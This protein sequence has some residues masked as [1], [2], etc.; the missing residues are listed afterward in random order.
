MATTRIVRAHKLIIGFDETT[1]QSIVYTPGELE[2][3]L[4]T[5]EVIRSGPIANDATGTPNDG[6]EWY[7][8]LMPGFVE[9]HTHGPGAPTDDVFFNWLYPEEVLQELCHHGTTSV[10]ATVTFANK[11]KDVVT[12]I[13]QR[14]EAI[15]GVPATTLHDRA[16]LEGVHCEG[17]MIQSYG[18]L[19]DGS[20]YE[21]DPNT[22]LSLYPKSL[23]IITIA[24]SADART[25]YSY[26][27]AAL[28]KG[29]VVAIGHDRDT[30]AEDII[31]QMRCARDCGAQPL[32]VTHMFNVMSH[33]HRKPGIV[34]F[35]LCNRYPNLPQ[36]EGLVPPTVEII[37]DMLHVDPL[38]L[39]NTL[40]TLGDRGCLITDAIATKHFDGHLMFNDRAVEVRD[41]KLVLKGT[42]TIAGSC[43]TMDELLRNAVNIIGLPITEAVRLLSERPARVARLYPYIGCLKDK[44]RADFVALSNDLE[45]RRVVVAG[46]TVF[47]SEGAKK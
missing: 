11:H 41:G 21:A 28:A 38:V 34:D 5:G 6:A 32:H 20:D 15:Y 37:G 35:A 39:G 45:V 16:S 42:S 23:K 9:I 46:N 12:T 44:S 26:T 24:P 31:G 33:N 25:G 2:I 4:T 8:I 36:Y 10:V 43:S 30:S 7:D 29:V 40:R 3:D 1:Q 17:P 14:L 13:A 22:V 27:K 18:G 47:E 19:P